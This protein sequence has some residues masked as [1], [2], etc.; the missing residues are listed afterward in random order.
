MGFESY[1]LDEIAQALQEL[2]G[3]MQEQQ[4]QL[5]RAQRVVVEQ[6]HVQPQQPPAPALPDETTKLALMVCGMQAR[7]LSELAAALQGDESSKAAAANNAAALQGIA[8]LLQA[9]PG[10]VDV[11][12]VAGL[13]EKAGIGQREGNEHGQETDNA[14]GTAANDNDAKGR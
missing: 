10:T 12:A 5:Q 6:I 2:L 11:D 13:L 14:A 9:A 4:A 7:A 1:G 3:Q 8:G